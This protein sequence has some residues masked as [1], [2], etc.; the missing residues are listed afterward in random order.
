M[1][2][3]ISQSNQTTTKHHFHQSDSQAKSSF[4]CCNT[5]QPSLALAPKTTREMTRTWRSTRRMERSRNDQRWNRKHPGSLLPVWHFSN[6]SMIGRHRYP[7][8]LLSKCCYKGSRQNNIPGLPAPAR[9]IPRRPH[10][11]QPK[12]TCHVG[13]GTTASSGARWILLIINTVSIVIITILRWS[14]MGKNSGKSTASS[15]NGQTEKTC[16]AET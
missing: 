12:P 4:R 8:Q 7:S 9:D 13:K 2:S 6:S 1:A 16:R 15:S 11:I 3:F 14:R 5:S 10:L